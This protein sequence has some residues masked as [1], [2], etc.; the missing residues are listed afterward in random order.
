MQING[1]NLCENCFR[2]LA[3]DSCDYCAKKIKF[4]S[5]AL[6][7]GTILFDRYVVG[8]PIE[9]ND[10]AIKYYAYDMNSDKRTL[11]KEYFPSI[12]AN[13][14]ADQVSAM[15]IDEEAY[16][17]GLE[18]FFD[19]AKALSDFKKCSGIIKIYKFFNQNGTSYYVTELLDGYDLDK[20]LKK[21]SR[22]IPE[23]AAVKIILKTIDALEDIHRSAPCHGSL[24]P[25]DIFLCSNGQ[26]KLSSVGGLFVEPNESSAKYAPVERKI[27]NYG[28]ASAATDVYSL[29][30]IMLQMITGSIPNDPISRLNE[31]SLD[32]LGISDQLEAVLNKMLAVLPFDRYQSLSELREA[33]SS[34]LTLKSRVNASGEQMDAD[35]ASSAKADESVNEGNIVNVKDSIVKEELPNNN[36]IPE[37]AES[38]SENDNYIEETYD[39][40]SNDY[41]DGYEDDSYNDLSY[42]N[43]YYDDDI[44][45]S[46][47]NRNDTRLLLAILYSLLGALA[48]FLVMV[49]V[50]LFA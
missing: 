40:S 29:G 1:K 50:L 46:S 19:E 8:K 20:Y 28:R 34:R 24:S 43:E 4:V 5:A 38:V 41:D 21:L 22:K 33:L 23:T 42:D 32:L 18:S 48:I 2:E 26:V 47:G 12:F 14:S 7:Q 25:S 35:G 49:I 36:D 9:E 10:N 3:A 15:P 17:D 44:E 13:R 30:A 37:E 11:I 45:Q 27:K 39:E 16:N 6:P 31:D